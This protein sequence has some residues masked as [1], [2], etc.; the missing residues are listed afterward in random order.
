MTASSR[1]SLLK[2]YDHISYSGPPE[3]DPL[4]SHDNQLLSLVQLWSLDLVLEYNEK[5]LY[6]SDYNKLKI[7]FS[8]LTLS[9]YTTSSMIQ[10][11]DISV[12]WVKCLSP[13]LRDILPFSNFYVVNLHGINRLKKVY[14]IYSQLCD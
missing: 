11:R 2:E 4:V 13:F 5:I 8:F 1:P 14:F 3:G 9:Y 12:Y 10:S 6:R 7:T